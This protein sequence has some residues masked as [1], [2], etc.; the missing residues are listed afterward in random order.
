MVSKK[1]KKQHTDS[2]YVSSKQVACD[3][4]AGALGHP[5]V[6]L[7]MGQADEI[8]C[9]YCSKQFVYKKSS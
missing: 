4:G 1:N 2:E 8:I 6:Y 7:N 3:G 5:N 9:P